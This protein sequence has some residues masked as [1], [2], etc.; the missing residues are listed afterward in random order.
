MTKKLF[1]F[2]PVCVL[3][4]FSLAE[5]AEA[6]TPWLDKEH[7]EKR[8]D[9]LTKVAGKGPSQWRVIWTKDPAT[10]ATVSWTT[11]SKGK[12]HQVSYGTHASGKDDKKLSA[13]VLSHRDGP[14]SGAD[15]EHYHHARLTGLKPS[16]TYRFVIT[17]DGESSPPMHFT[18]APADDREFHLLFGGDSRSGH[19]ARAQVNLLMAALAEE[20]KDLIAFAHGGD[21]IGSGKSWSQWSRWLS[22]HE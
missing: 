4:S 3:I 21:Y 5:S 15:G 8:M 7:V 9:G 22:Q 20:D 12:K 10:S 18:S 19:F 2:V 11:A 16:T 13:V 14:Y 1:S 6:K 17:S